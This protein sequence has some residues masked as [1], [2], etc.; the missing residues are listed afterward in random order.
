VFHWDQLFDLHTVPVIIGGTYSLGVT[1]LLH[2]GEDA[3]NLYQ[4][5][6]A[7]FRNLFDIGMS[8]TIARLTFKGGDVIWNGIRFETPVIPAP[9][10][11][12]NP[13]CRQPI[14][15][16]LRRGFL[17]QSGTGMTATSTAHVLQMTAVLI[18]AATS[19]ESMKQ[20]IDT[21]KDL[22]YPRYSG[23]DIQIR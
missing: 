18:Q 16:D 1:I 10:C 6:G 4:S 23:F 13:V 15:G 12:R 19:R 3:T 5:G 2:F 7:M 11:G 22:R 8:S 14:S 9:L 20:A 17:P 21:A